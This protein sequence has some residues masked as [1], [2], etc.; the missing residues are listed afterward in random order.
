MGIRQEG[1][2]VIVC[3][4][5]FVSKRPKSKHI[6]ARI[7]TTK[8]SAPSWAQKM[9]HLLHAS[10]FDV[11][12]T[13]ILTRYMISRLM[14]LSFRQ[15]AFLMKTGSGRFSNI[16]GLINYSASVKRALPWTMKRVTNKR[17]TPSG[18]AKRHRKDLQFLS[19]SLMSLWRRLGAGVLGPTQ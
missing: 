7:L 5:V 3:N 14:K 11:I 6:Y 1:A 17:S 18:K 12:M 4:L 8:W 10:H 2:I 16:L 19:A 13:G 15:W 9:S